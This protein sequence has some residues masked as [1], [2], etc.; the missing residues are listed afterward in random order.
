[1]V[2]RSRNWVSRRCSRRPKRCSTRCSSVVTEEAEAKEVGPGFSAGVERG[3]VRVDVEEGGEREREPTR[4]GERVW[5]NESGRPSVGAGGA[6]PRQ[7]AQAWTSRPRTPMKRSR[8]TERR[9]RTQRLVST[10]GDAH[11]SRSRSC[12]RTGAEGDHRA[13]VCQKGVPTWMRQKRG[14]SA[15]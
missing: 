15:A 9:Q 5:V 12:Q 1:M 6:L 11:Q 14:K 3:G 7:G 8:S 2:R 10:I 13:R 4:G